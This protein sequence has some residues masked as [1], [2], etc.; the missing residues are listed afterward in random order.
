[1]ARFEKSKL[2]KAN[3]KPRPR[4]FFKGNGKARKPDNIV[5]AKTH[6]FK[7]DQEY[8]KKATEIDLISIRD[9][10]RVLSVMQLPEQEISS[11]EGH[12]L[13]DPTPL[14]TL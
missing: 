5:E 4:S 8:I 14:K 12:T 3:L 9:V 10:K 13:V 1:M 2:K 7:A 11:T 6:L